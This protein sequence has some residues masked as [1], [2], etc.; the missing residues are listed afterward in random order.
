MTS[1][2]LWRNVG[3]HFAVTR[4]SVARNR[5]PPPTGHEALPRITHSAANCAA[6]IGGEGNFSFLIVRSAVESRRSFEAL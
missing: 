5:P 1:P 6:V 4:G 3:P 2:N